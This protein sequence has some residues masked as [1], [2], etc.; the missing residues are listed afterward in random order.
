MRDSQSFASW[1]II[2]KKQNE[3]TTKQNKTKAS[4]P[5]SHP[6]PQK[7]SLPSI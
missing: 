1:G 3:T 2:V 4:N 7:H 6:L 5:T